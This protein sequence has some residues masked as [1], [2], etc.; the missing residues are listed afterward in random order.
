MTESLCSID[1]NIFG[2]HF[3]ISK[4]I[5][6]L[7]WQSKCTSVVAP[8][9]LLVFLSPGNPKWH[10]LHSEPLQS[11]NHQ[12]MLKKSNYGGGKCVISDSWNDRVS[13]SSGLMENTWELPQLVTISRERRDERVCSGSFAAHTKAI[14]RTD[15]FAKSGCKLDC[16]AVRH[17]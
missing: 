10:S 3:K 13:R 17:F 14:T 12:D 6:S 2:I 7:G 4:L 11:E 9:L 5:F 1:W 16:G 15:R 8:C